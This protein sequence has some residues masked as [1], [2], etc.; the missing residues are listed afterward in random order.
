MMQIYFETWDSINSEDEYYN[1]VLNLPIQNFIYFVKI[2]DK[3]FEFIEF[4]S[5]NKKIKPTV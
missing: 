2:R 4:N 3:G 1:S 5:A